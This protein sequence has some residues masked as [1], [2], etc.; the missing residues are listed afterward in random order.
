MATF[1][2]RASVATHSGGRAGIPASTSPPPVCTSSAAAARAMRS[3][4]AR[5]YPHEGRASVARPSNHEK[6]HP[7]VG[8]ASASATSSSNE[9][10][11][12]MP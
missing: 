9:R 1:G 12:I 11:S 8:S 4:M 7:S 6:S 10:D 2:G 5:W 3:P